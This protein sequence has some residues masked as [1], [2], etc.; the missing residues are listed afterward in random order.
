MASI[1]ERPAGSGR[2][3]LR[4]YAGR[5]DGRDVYVTRTFEGTERAARKAAA[6]LETEY[7]DRRAPLPGQGTVAEL[8]EAWWT[9]KDWQSAGSR[10]QARGDLDRY[11]LPE[12]GPIHLA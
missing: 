2:W 10:R 8:L 4:V 9:T 6:R 7:E 1:R 12:L 3:Q 11:L 5:Q